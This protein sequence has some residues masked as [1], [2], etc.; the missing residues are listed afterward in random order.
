MTAKKSVDSDWAW[1]RSSS[2]PRSDYLHARSFLRKSIRSFFETRDF[3]EVETPLVVTCPGL[4][5]HLDAFSVSDA[6]GSLGWLITSPEYQMK[7]LLSAGFPRIYQLARCFRTGELGDLHE[8]EFSMLEWYRTE[9]GSEDVMRDTEEL[10]AR[11][12]MDLRGSSAIVSERGTLNFAPP[13]ERL[14]LREAFDRYARRDLESVISNEEVFFRTFIDEVEPRLGFEKP[15]FI[16]H[17]PAPLASLARLHEDDPRYADRFE[18]YIQGIEL[19]NGFG[20]LT[21]PV[22]QRAR[23][24]R[25]QET[26]RSLGK[27]VY[28]IDERFL[29]ALTDGMPRSGGN[30]LGVDRLF[31]VL[32][33]AQAIKDSIAIPWERR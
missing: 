33:G 15:V 9:A 26:R 27:P 12:A 25:D 14:S 20:E 7:R 23:F 8:P 6:R 30:A 16:T 22:E 1:F 31:L 10:V 2:K 18:A 32:F 29:S 11:C 19:C 4:D 21:D 5:V 28:P 24:V 17:W 3:L 13:W